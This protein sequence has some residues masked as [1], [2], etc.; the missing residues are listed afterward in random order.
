[1]TKEQLEK[2]LEKARHQIEGLKIELERSEKS[3][4]VD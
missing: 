2:E 4:F 1:M 3:H